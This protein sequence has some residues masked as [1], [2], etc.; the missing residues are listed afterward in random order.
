MACYVEKEVSG[1]LESQGEYKK[2]MVLEQGN[3]VLRQ[4]GGP[5]VSCCPRVSRHGLTCEK[6]GLL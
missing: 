2:G 6:C 4:L 3:L 1:A 5:R